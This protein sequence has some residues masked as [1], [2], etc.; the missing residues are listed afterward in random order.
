MLLVFIMVFAATFFVAISTSPDTAPKR[1]K[2][3]LLWVG[4]N[5]RKE[6]IIYL[7]KNPFT[8]SKK[9]L[10]QIAE[11]E[12]IDFSGEAYKSPDSVIVMKSLE[13]PYKGRRKFQKGLSICVQ[14]SKDSH[15][16]E[17]AYVE[18]DTLIFEAIERLSPHVLK[19]SIAGSSPKIYERTFTV[20]AEPKDAWKQ[21]N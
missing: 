19:V 12:Y 15:W 5:D 4:S 18:P 21:K 11:E 20:D 10:L 2:E 14:S 9:T 7:D 1:Q 8:M 17:I 16:Y 3:L 6:R 13:D